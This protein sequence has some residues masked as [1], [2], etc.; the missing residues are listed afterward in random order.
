MIYA[1]IRRP[2]QESIVVQR[3]DR[4]RRTGLGSEARK[5]V[6]RMIYRLKFCTEWYVL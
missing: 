3:N 1:L 5:A 2:G 6:N 4:S